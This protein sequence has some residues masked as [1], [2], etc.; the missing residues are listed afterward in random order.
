MDIY[1]Q[2]YEFITTHIIELAS[3]FDSLPLF[4]LFFIL[5]PDF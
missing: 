2:M 5:V 4:E 1:M 3:W